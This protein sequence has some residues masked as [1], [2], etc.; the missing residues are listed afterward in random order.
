MDACIH[1]RF[2]YKHSASLGLVHI[3]DL[4]SHVP[5]METKCTST[6]LL[7]AASL[8][9]FLVKQCMAWW[10]C[11]AHTPPRRLLHV[12]G[13]LMHSTVFVGNQL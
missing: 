10:P 12:F 6:T 11:N 9:L 7:H 2:M 4:V 1:L 3:D 5:P 8:F 13:T